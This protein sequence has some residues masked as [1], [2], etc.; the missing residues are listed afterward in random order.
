MDRVEQQAWSL[1][2]QRSG[3]QRERPTV[4]LQAIQ[5]YKVL[6]RNGM[7]YPIRFFCNLLPKDEALFE[8]I[9]EAEFW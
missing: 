8:T 3:L 2:R 7:A 5:G 4:F 6:C 9:A 1:T